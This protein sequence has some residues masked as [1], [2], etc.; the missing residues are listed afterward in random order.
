MKLIADSNIVFSLI[1]SGKKGRIYQILERYD[2]DL[3]APEELVSEFREYV[4]LLRKKSEDFEK[5]TL[6]AFSLIAIV[7]I[8]VYSDKISEALG[9]AREFD[10]K[11]APFI[12]LALKLGIPVWTEDKDMLRHSFLTGRYLALDTEAVKEL[13]E[14]AKLEDALEKLRNRLSLSEKDV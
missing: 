10:E 1:I 4:S 14:G 7:P 3:L 2:I 6:L 5:R 8:E 9:I 13:L 12:A 11:D